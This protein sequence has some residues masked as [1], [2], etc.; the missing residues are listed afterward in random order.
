MK[1]GINEVLKQVRLFFIPYLILLCACLILKAIFTKQ[2]IYFAVNGV[3][4]A[5]AD[6]IA[7]YVTD[8]GN[9]WTI[10]TLSAIL[11]LFNYRAGFLMGSTYA[12]TS[13]TAQVVKYIADAPRPTLLYH[14]Q[15]SR[16][17]LVKG[18]YMLQ[19]NSFPSGHTVTAF[20]TAIVICYLI[21]EKRWSFLLLIAAVAV[22]YSRMYLSEHFFEDVT[23][24]S[25]LGVLLTVCWLAF[26]ERKAFIHKAGWQGGLLRRAKKKPGLKSQA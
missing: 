12:I 25:A 2:E 22:G 13:L 3:Y 10:I 9:G 6:A 26:I 18:V 19:F 24:G 23:T 20:S 14:D 4:S 21:K 8:A 7:P 16:I 15:L 5:A 1:I 17:H 11:L